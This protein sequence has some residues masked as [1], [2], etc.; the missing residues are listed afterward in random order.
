MYKFFLMDSFSNKNEVSEKFGQKGMGIGSK[1][2]SWGKGDSELGNEILLQVQTV[3]FP[4]SKFEHGKNSKSSW[5]A[6]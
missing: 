3:K 1:W 2:R 5:M 6:T 4:G